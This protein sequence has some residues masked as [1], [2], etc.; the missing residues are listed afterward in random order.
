[1][2]PL[3]GAAWAACGVLLGGVALIR[4]HAARLDP[5]PPPGGG[6][7]PSVCV[8]IPARDEAGEVGRAL[9]SW[10]A[11]DLREL[12]IVVVD[13][14]STDATPALLAARAGAHPDRLR[15]IRNDALPPGWLGKNHALHL[16]TQAPEARQAEW[17]LFVDADA[18][19]DPDLLGRAFAYLEGHPADVLALLFAMEAEGFWER[20]VLPLASAAF[21][22]AIPPHRIPDP[23]HPA[24]CGIG[25][26]TLVRRSAYEAVGGHAAAPLEAVDDMMLARRLKRAGYVNRVACGGPALRVRM[27]HGLRDIVRG[28]RK[29]AAALPGWGVLPV[30][31]G[32]VLAAHLAPIWL[33]LVGH[34]W[35]GGLLW[36]LV[37]A[38]VGDVSQRVTRRPMDWR[39]ALWPL[40]GFVVV[41]GMA[42]AFADRLRGVNRWRGRTVRLNA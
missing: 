35:M 36:L 28:L 4:R 5:L 33:P 29:N 15:V 9:D 24:F 20:L 27:Y 8:C 32:V 17:L 13:D 14:G 2:T 12:R 40:N 42:W 23:R 6:P 10:L 34:P 7:R 37:P 19:A 21:L 31:M 41:A 22:L 30:V 18:V 1:M 3:D 11:Q 25:A 39:W 38:L 16:A 26:F